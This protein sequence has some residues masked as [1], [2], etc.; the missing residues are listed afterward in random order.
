MTSGHSDQGLRRRLRAALPEAEVSVFVGVA[1]GPFPVG[2]VHRVRGRTDAT[3][4]TQRKSVCP[5]LVL[6]TQRTQV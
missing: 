1:L 5:A 6:Q 4:L 3:Q 2:A